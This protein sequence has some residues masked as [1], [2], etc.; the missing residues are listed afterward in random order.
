M[1]TFGEDE[2]EDPLFTGKHYFTHQ[3]K[4]LKTAERTAKGRVQCHNDHPNLEIKMAVMID[5]LPTGNNYNQWC[6]GDKQNG[7]TKS[8]IANEI[9]QMI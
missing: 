8:V 2:W 5:W 6:S 7:A 3:N 1:L 9:S 4:A